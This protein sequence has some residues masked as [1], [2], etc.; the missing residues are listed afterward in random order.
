[1]NDSPRSLEKLSDRID[2]LERRVH[3]LEHPELR[4]A[5]AASLS[6]TTDSVSKN[7]ESPLQAGTIF[8]VLGRAMLGIA[9][10]YVLRAVTT[11]GVAPALLVSTI[12]VAYAFGWLVCA[13][14][15]SHALSRYVYA[16][17]SALILAPMLWEVT[18]HFNVLTPVMAAGV[19]AGFATLATVLDSR[20]SDGRPAWIV[21]ATAVIL[22]GLL[23]FATHH[24]LPF[25]FAVLIAFF[26]VE[27]GRVRTFP[28]PVW[29]LMALV[30]DAAIWGSIFIYSGP[31]SARSDYP[32]LSAIALITPACLLFAINGTTVAVRV[33]VGESRI[34]AFETVQLLMSFSLAITGVLF[35][36]P[37]HGQLTVGAVCLVMAAAIYPATFLRLQRLS[38]P[39]NFRVFGMLGAALL[40][41]GAI[42]SLPLDAAA[43]LLAAVS[44]ITYLLAGRKGSRMFE[45]HGAVFLCTSVAISGMP[46]YVF[47]ALASS[48]PGRPALSA[49]VLSIAAALAFIEDRESRESS[50]IR[51]TLQFV[52]ALVAACGVSALF[53]HGVLALFSLASMTEA[54]HIAFL[55]T[56][57]VSFISLCFAFVGSRW[58]LAAMTKLAYV[59]LAFV[60]A[61]LF[62]EDLRHGNM[63]FIAASIFLFA[64]SLIAVPRLV[65]WGAKL[66]AAHLPQMATHGRG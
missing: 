8:P 5:A 46:R 65:H 61:K 34:G 52:P 66:R 48:I 6:A 12:A 64:I 13:L 59:A 39:R 30:A 37:L 43:I 22:A 29:P 58:G 53:A 36:A 10:A 60:A 9:G 44:C 17:T 7:E 2:D 38:D 21:Q 40:I 25:L 3:A 57:T 50:T 32:S 51:K 23:A 4:S 14:R 18:L 20:E 27:Y 49:V 31:Q 47:G 1:M 62:F 56:L 42:W 63:A 19:L 28:E 54:H 55:R 41:A 33:F 35:F 15:T 24:I 45:L 16:G 26:V 11:S